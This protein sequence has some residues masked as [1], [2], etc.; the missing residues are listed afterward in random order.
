MANLARG[1]LTNWLPLPQK[2]CHTP[3][4]FEHSDAE[5][6]VRSQPSWDSEYVC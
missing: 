2:N 5:R 4:L 3:P 6:G 1:P